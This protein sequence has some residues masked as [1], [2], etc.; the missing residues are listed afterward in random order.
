[1]TGMVRREEAVSTRK[2]HLYADRLSARA[3]SEPLSQTNRAIYVSEG[4]A[5]VR[6]AGFAACLMCNSVWQGYAAITAS[7]GPEGAKL[8][9][10]ELSVKGPELLRGADVKSDL[11]V[12]GEPRIEQGVE[13]LM[14]CDRVDFPPGGVAF[15]HTHQGSGIRCLQNGRIRIETQGHDFWV[16]AGGAWFETGSDPVFA[17]TR[18][19]GP[20]HFIRVMI[21]PK[22]LLGKSSIR[23]VRPEDQD[24]PKSQKYQVFVDEPI[25]LNG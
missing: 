4:S 22:S 7:A 10:W 11:T 19:D 21:L 12:E 14:R 2:L 8:L 16:E 13:Y 18:Q 5:V 9:R 25:N 24:K 3:S 1:M 15:T 17:E 6:G 20:S 23:Y